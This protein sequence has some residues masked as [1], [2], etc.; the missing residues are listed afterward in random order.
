MVSLMVRTSRQ[1]WKYVK[2]YPKLLMK[3]FLDSANKTKTLSLVV[4]SWKAQLGRKKNKR[5][6]WRIA[7]KEDSHR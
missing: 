7:K 6:A 2:P 4:P 1:S 3:D 5:K